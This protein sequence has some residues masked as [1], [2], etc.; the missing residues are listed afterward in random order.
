MQPPSAQTV[1]AYGLL[2]GTS[3]LIALVG[4]GWWSL[5]R[6]DPLLALPGLGWAVALFALAHPTSDREIASIATFAVTFGLATISVLLA[7]RMPLVQLLVSGFVCWFLAAMAVA[8]V[9]WLRRKPWRGPRRWSAAVSFL[10]VM[11]LATQ[12]L[13]WPLVQS[14]YEPA[15]AGDRRLAVDVLTS[16]PLQP[17]ANVG[18]LLADQVDPP[19]PV[20]SVLR[21]HADVTFLNSIGSSG[22]HSG[23]ILLLAHPHAMAPAELVAVDDWV[24]RGG[25]ALVLADGLLT[26]PAPYPLGDARNPPITSMLGPLLAHWGLRLDAP[27]GL[28]AKP[29]AMVDQGTRVVLMSPGRLLATGTACHVSQSGYLADCRLGEGR[30]I[31]VADADLLHAAVWNPTLSDSNDGTEASWTASNP[32]WLIARLDNL[33]GITRRPAFARPVWVR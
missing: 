12:W 19:G 29:R 1:R 24:R 8:Y 23:H 31:I 11:G 26:W 10:V 4:G 30:A 16:L 18:A 7:N 2:L 9:G 6:V 5:G 3:L 33:A 21:G 15:S 22:P 27:V 14:M 25:N 32:H 13:G 17:R 28:D 20:L